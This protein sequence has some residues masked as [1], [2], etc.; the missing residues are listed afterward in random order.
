MEDEKRQRGFGDAR[1]SMALWS[2]LSHDY[3]LPRE[4][5]RI[6]TLITSG[7]QSLFEALTN[8]CIEK[9]HKS[10]VKLVDNIR[11]VA[12]PDSLHGYVE[13]VVRE[14]RSANPDTEDAVTDF[15]KM[16]RLK[17]ER[18]QRVY[19]NSGGGEVRLLAPWPRSG[20]AGRPQ[21]AAARPSASRRAPLPGRA[22]RLLGGNVPT[23]RSSHRSGDD[24]RTSRSAPSAC[25]AQPGEARR[26]PRRRHHRP[27]P[28]TRPSGARGGGPTYAQARRVRSART[29]GSQGLTP[30]ME[31][32]AYNMAPGTC[33]HNEAGA[34][35]S[36]SPGAN[37]A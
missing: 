24:A 30:A 7:D 21:V 9:H 6:V 16:S 8:L 4:P 17:P 23:G 3:G 13:Y 27:R 2:R 35:T 15:I 37:P 19:P 22:M 33:A 32:R 31:V 12:P 1:L 29:G 11:H 20:G 28:T 5:D 34:D 14:W 36:P 10:L 26:R 25:L 18:P